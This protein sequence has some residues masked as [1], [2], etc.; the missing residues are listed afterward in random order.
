MK[1]PGHGSREFPEGGH[2]AAVGF[3]LLGQIG[4]DGG[5]AAIAEGKF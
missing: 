2:E 4:H 1:A 3:T 5:N